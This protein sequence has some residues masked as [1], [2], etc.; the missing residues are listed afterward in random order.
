MRAAVGNARDKIR[1]VEHLLHIVHVLVRSGRVELAAQVVSHADVE[2]RVDRM[3]SVALSRFAQSQAFILLQVLALD[4]GD[5]DLIELGGDYERNLRLER[6]A[7][8]RVAEL[9]FTFRSGSG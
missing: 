5:E 1:T 7:P 4:A 9:G 2:H 3:L 8:R 6:R